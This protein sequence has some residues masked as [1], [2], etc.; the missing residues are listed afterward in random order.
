MSA[1]RRHHTAAGERRRRA[2]ALQPSGRC[3]RSWLDVDRDAVLVIHTTDDDVE[4]QG[5]DHSDNRFA[6]AGCEVEHLH[7]AFLLQLF[8]AFVELLVSGVLQPYT[9]EM[10]GRKP[11]DVDEAYCASVVQ[12]VAD[13]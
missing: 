11:R 1:V 5:T 12:R 7:Q 10:L 3:I 6:T 2:L 4:L 13:A 8:H 9:A